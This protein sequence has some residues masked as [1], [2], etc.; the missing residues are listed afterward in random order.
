MEPN[1]RI[2]LLLS[3]LQVGD[4]DVTFAFMEWMQLGQDVDGEAMFDESGRSVSMSGDGNTLVIGAPYNDGSGNRA[5]HVRA[6]RF[7]G[8]SWVQLG[9]DID[10]EAKDD[11]SGWSVSLSNDGNTLAIGALS[12]DGNGIDSGHARVYR[13]DGVDWNQLGQDIDGKTAGDRAGWSVALSGDGKSL[14]IGSPGTLGDGINAGR[15][16]VY[17]FDG[18][19][20][21]RVGQDI[22]GESI[23]DSFGLSVTSSGDG[24]TLAIGSPRSDGA[25]GQAGVY[26]FDGTY[27]T[28][29]GQDID[30]EAAGD[31]SGRSVSVSEDGNTLAIGMT[32]FFGAY[33]HVGQVRVYHFDG[34]DWTQIGQKLE[35]IVAGNHF[36]FSVSLS[37]DGDKVAVGAPLKDGNDNFFGH[38]H[39][40]DFDGVDWIQIGQTIVGESTFDQS[41]W[42][43]SLNTDGN[44]LA[45]GAP[46]NDDVSESAGHARVYRFDGADW[47]QLGGDIDGKARFEHSGWSVS[48]SGDGN[49]LVIGAPGDDFY[50]DPTGRAR[51]Y[52][53]NGT[54]WTQIGED[55]EGEAYGDEAGYSVS[56][57]R[58]WHDVGSRSTLQRW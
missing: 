50:G 39:V 12:N 15:V 20:W 25:A 31:V 32:G 23:S 54:V 16:Q 47:N 10:G 5:G 9:R 48:L 46:F 51:A 41:G 21:M 11:N 34:T 19:E 13:F 27:W 49:M 58:R 56:I 45:I 36:G 17:R 8:T 38:T 2:D 57:W 18:I 52:R 42:S 37:G 53:F 28:Q 43:V 35:G 7:D 26:H 22:D 6:Y 33:N 30:G 14:V 55:I 44:T 40:Y 24:N 29:I 4:R 1:E 3:N